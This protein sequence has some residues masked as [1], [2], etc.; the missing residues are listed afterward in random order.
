MYA[1]YFGLN[2][3]PFSLSPDPDFLL[4]TPKHR[5]A[6]GGLL[7]AVIA[8]KGFLMLTGEAGTGKTTLVKKMLSSIPSSCAQFSVVVNPMLNASE[9]LE[10]ILMDFGV[11]D[12]PPS[13]AMR[14]ALLRRLLLQADKEGRTS[15]LVVD[16]AHLLTSELLEE[17][18][19]LSNF[20]TSEHKLL[21]IIL[22]GQS[23][24]NSILDQNSM[25]HVKQRIAARLDLAALAEKEI[26]E[27]IQKRWTCAGGLGPIPISESA[28][29]LVSRASAGIPRVINALCDAVLTNAYGKGTRNVEAKDMLEVLSDMHLIAAT[30]YDAPQHVP[31]TQRNLPAPADLPAPFVFTSFQRYTPKPSRAHKSLRWTHWLGLGSESRS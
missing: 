31:L 5:E 6:L 28:L 12:I 8:R 21:Q 23:E 20:E 24:L 16:E 11:T 1:H 22:A 17:V 27:Y 2:K 15:V 13:K 30:T 29:A 9:F 18:R 3:S 4:L 14:L 10:S 26:L 25:R 7:F 19:L